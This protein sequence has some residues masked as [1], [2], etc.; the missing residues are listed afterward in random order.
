MEI[1]VLQNNWVD[2]AIVVYIGKA[3]NLR[4]KLGQYR[5]YGLGR[6][7]GHQGGRYIWQLADHAELLVAWRETPDE[8]P[9]VVKNA[10]DR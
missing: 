7:V 8:A 3:T 4:A 9:H 5:R 10:H 6:P 2:D 1:A